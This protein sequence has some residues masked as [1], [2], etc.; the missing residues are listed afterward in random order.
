[1]NKLITTIITIL[2]L[3]LWYCNADLLILSKEMAAD[4]APLTVF[5][6]GILIL[7]AL[8]YSVMSAMA[9]VFINKFIYAL[10]FA[11]LDGI[12]VYL[13]IN[14]DQPYFL[15]IVAVFYSL[16]TAY[17]VIIA[18]LL[19]HQPTESQPKTTEPKNNKMKALPEKSDP[20]YAL[21]ISAVRS[22]SA[23]KD[24]NEAI[25]NILKTTDNPAVKDYIEKRYGIYPH[26]QKLPL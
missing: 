10:I 3:H 22:I 26:Q 4:G 7:F 5:T 23:S 14:V 20:N 17:I 6:Y 13:R 16:Y 1:M 21:I 11:L 19:K 24:S 2:A 25:S 8:S 18:W 9:V 15:Y 12:V